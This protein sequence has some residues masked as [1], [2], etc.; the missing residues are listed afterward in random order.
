MAKGGF[1]FAQQ[2]EEQRNSLLQNTVDNKYSHL[3][4]GRMDGN[5]PS[6]EGS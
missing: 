3:S 1:I 2:E 4:E 5:E 6:A